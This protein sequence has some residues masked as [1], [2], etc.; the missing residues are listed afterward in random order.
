MEVSASQFVPAPQDRAW[1]LL[2]DTARY[3]EWVI[4][5][6]E[7]T[8]PGGPTR[9]GSAYREVNP[10]I[11][12][13]KVRT[14]WRV[15]EFDPPRRQVHAST[16]WP[17]ARR[18]DVILEL[19][20]QGDGSWLTLTLRGAPSLGAAGAL[21]ARLMRWKVARDNRRTVANFVELAARAP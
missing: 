9:Q 20:P 8:A 14:S 13:W 16:D 19:A 17:G 12:P 11:G 7:V 18:V 5:T 10:V 3:P 6:D 1:E 4:G 21:L 15:E 2:S